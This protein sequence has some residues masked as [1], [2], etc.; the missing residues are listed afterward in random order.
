MQERTSP[1]L[2]PTPGQTSY[3]VAYLLAE[4]EE[5]KRLA[6]EMGYGT[7]DLRSWHK[8]D[9]PIHSLISRG[10]AVLSSGLP[11]SSLHTD[12]HNGRNATT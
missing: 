2:P 3:D 4:I 5:L 6:K 12:N 7:S 9:I 1:H 11:P 10:A 8:A